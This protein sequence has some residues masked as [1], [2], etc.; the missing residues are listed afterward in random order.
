MSSPYGLPT[1]MDLFMLLPYRSK[2]KEELWKEIFHTFFWED[3]QILFSGSI[4]IFWG[5][6]PFCFTEKLASM[7]RTKES[8]GCGDSMDPM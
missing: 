3:L 2:L 6:C 5:V 1:G 7:F 8:A 4:W